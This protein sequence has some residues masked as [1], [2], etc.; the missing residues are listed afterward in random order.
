METWPCVFFSLLEEKFRQV[1]LAFQT[2]PVTVVQQIAIYLLRS[3]RKISQIF[4]INSYHNEQH[5][6]RTLLFLNTF[7]K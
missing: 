6:A 4:E 7:Q 1:T 3:Y 5:T 2:S